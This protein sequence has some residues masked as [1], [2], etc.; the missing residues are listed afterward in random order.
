MGR[1]IRNIV[2]V[3]IWLVITNSPG[4]ARYAYADEADIFLAN[5]GVDIVLP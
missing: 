1:I 4:G 3:I 2:V 5:L